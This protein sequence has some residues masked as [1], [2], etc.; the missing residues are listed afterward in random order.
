VSLREVSVSRGG[1]DSPE[2]RLLTTETT[3]CGI[4]QY[5][6]PEFP[7]SS[8]ISTCPG[9][10]MVATPEPVGEKRRRS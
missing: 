9:A 6:F 4:S 10:A 7:N 5:R 2:V 8:S 3:L 1:V